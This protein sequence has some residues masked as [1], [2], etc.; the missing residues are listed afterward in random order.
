MQHDILAKLILPLVL[1]LGIKRMS[2]YF[3]IL[4]ARHFVNG[5]VPKIT[6]VKAFIA[7][8]RGSFR[9]WVQMPFVDVCIPLVDLAYESKTYDDRVNLCKNEH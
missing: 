6:S 9:A 3:L 5:L 4:K 2:R 1:T 7:Y 8:V